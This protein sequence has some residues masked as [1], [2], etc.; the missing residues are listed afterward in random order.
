VE[1]Q[2]KL[3]SYVPTV[4]LFFTQEFPVAGDITATRLIDVV[5]D[6]T[7]A[8]KTYC[9]NMNYE[10]S[11]VG[12]SAT[13]QIDGK[14][15]IVIGTGGNILG[16]DQVNIKLALEPLFKLPIIVENDV[17]CAAIGEHWIGSGQ[18]FKNLFVYTIG[19]GIGG[20][21]IINNSLYAGA[22]GIA[23]EF[24]HMSIH[25]EGRLCS[26]G[27]SG[28]FEQYGSM[29]ALIKSASHAIR[30]PVRDGRHLFELL[31]TDYGDRLSP[32]IE[33]FIHYHSVA[34]TNVVHLLNPEAVII[35]GGVS[36][37]D[38]ILIQPII[39]A[40]QQRAMPNFTQNLV[41]APTQLGNQAGMIGAV[42]NLL[43]FLEVHKE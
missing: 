15:G 7:H 19:T 27:G 14:K 22:N 9:E 39:K 4:R 29:T 26:C 17:N 33:S 25:H 18:A 8:F 37:Q 34:I 1:L 30:Q 24:G 35:G 2:L 31:K 43:N 11:G 20:A 36:V 42:K 40:V 28:C 32:V 12:V 41:I 3:D 10:I 5:I 21:I 13:G 16:W 23:G 38:K 6:S